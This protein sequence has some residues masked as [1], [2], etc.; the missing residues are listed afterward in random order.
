VD[1]EVRP[2]LP[3]RRTRRPREERRSEILAIAR[4]V[5]AERGYDAASVAE[6][7]RRGGVVEGTV[8]AYF[9]T[10][11][12]LLV[13]VLRGF[14]EPLIA[15]AEASLKQIR[16]AESRLRFLIARQ[17]RAFTQDLDLCRLVIREIRPDLELY[18]DAV[19][20]L[21]RRYTAVA[22]ETIEQGI[23]DGELRADLVPSVVR[24]LIYGGIEHAVWGFVFSGEPVDVETVTDQLARAVLSGILA[25][26]APAE[27]TAERLERVLT[28]LEE[29]IAG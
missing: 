19:H 16:G 29:R 23:R 4:K 10:K 18:G 2:S 3:R 7:A 14:Y 24:D 27:R 8:Y 21:N 11:R 1:G 6:I 17:L 25:R 28:K 20:G 15:E 9:P 22:L 13:E 5:F 26:E 12:D